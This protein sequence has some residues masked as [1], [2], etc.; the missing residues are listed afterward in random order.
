MLNPTTS[1]QAKEAGQQLA[2][3]MAGDWKER[4]LL[5]LRG[6]LQAHAARGNETMAMEQFRAVAKEHP[7]STKAWGPLPM[8]ACKAGLLEPMTHPDGSPVMRLAESVK[9]HRHPVRCWRL[10]SFFSAPAAAEETR[11]LIET[12]DSLARRQPPEVEGRGGVLQMGATA[13]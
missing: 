4:V 2:L 12:Q 10:A 1:R 7:A 11:S 5:E 9:T 8:L 13:R 3:D 6:W